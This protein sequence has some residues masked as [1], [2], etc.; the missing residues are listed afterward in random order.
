[1]SDDVW[2]YVHQHASSVY[3]GTVATV[4][5]ELP[6]EHGTRRNVYFLVGRNRQCAI[7]KQVGQVVI[8]RAEIVQSLSAVINVVFAFGQLYRR[9]IVVDAVAERCSTS[10]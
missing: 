3:L 8:S 6:F 7:G 1:M 9:S 10:F 4:D 5:L 2:L